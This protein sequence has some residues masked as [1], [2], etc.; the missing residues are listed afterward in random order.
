MCIKNEVRDKT[1]KTGLYIWQC[2]QKSS[3]EDTLNLKSHNM[4]EHNP[5]M[6]FKCSAILL[7]AFEFTGLTQSFMINFLCG[8]D[9]KKGGQ[10]WLNVNLPTYLLFYV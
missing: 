3:S 2:Q 1:Y 6:H 7:N 9:F 4:S 10:H 5:Q 8:R